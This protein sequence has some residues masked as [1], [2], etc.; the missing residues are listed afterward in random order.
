[1]LTPEQEALLAQIMGS[2]GLGQLQAPVPSAAPLGPEPGLL[3]PGQM[4]PARMPMPETGGLYPPNMEGVNVKMTS[5]AA[6]YGGPELPPLARAQFGAPPSAPMDLGAVAAAGA[7]QT[8]I[9]TN[10]A[11]MPPMPSGASPAQ[12]AGAVPAMQGLFADKDELR[13]RIE[14]MFM[15]WAAG[16]GGTWQDSIAAGGKAMAV[17]KLTRKEKKELAA[18]DNKTREWAIANG[19]DPAT[20]DAYVTAGQGKALIGLVEDYKQQAAKAA[21]PQAT[22][23]GLTPQTG[24][25]E[26]GN[27]VLIQL[28]KD[29]TAIR[30][31]LPEGV[32]LSKEPIRLDAGTHFVLL[33]PITRQPVGQISKELAEAEAQK[34]R[35]KAEGEA[36][37]AAP[38]QMANA[39]IALKGIEDIRNSP[40]LDR[41]TGFSSFGNMVPGTGG[42]GFQSQVDQLKGGAFLTAIQ[43]LQGMGALSNAEGQTATAAIAR[44]D[45]AQSREDFMKALADYEEIVRRGRDRAAKR[46]GAD[47]SAPAA[48]AGNRVVIDGVTIE[49]I[50]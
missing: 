21:A 47:P 12:P 37:S 48:P 27:P 45:T 39:D 2:G 26:N 50:R 36:T 15:G 13:A 18:S 8:A 41:G 42:Y 3:P 44:L 5:P 25:D 40:Y 9:A 33:D 6:P 1:M 14:D 34:A 30:T 38:T 29:G 28:G 7:P 19:V 24:V 31:P 10:D 23:Y 16:A 35:G 11:P 43:Q 17:G 20:A 4:M 49:E 32:K 22:E 46:I